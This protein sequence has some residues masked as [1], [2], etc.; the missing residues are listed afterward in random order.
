MSKESVRRQ[1]MSYINSLFLV[2][3]EA[4]ANRERFYISMLLGPQI[5]PVDTEAK[6][7]SCL[8]CR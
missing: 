2:T 4:V 8:C 1:K 5:R 7:S 6:G 3:L